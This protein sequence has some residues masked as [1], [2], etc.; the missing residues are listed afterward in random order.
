M[1]AYCPLCGSTEIVRDT[2]MWYCEIC[3]CGFKHPAN[4]DYDSK[5][6]RDYIG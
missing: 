1:V 5:E 4:S 3:N 2:D 6:K